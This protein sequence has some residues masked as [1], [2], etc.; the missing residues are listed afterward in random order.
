MLRD[1]VARVL[2]SSAAKL[3]MDKPL[4]NLGLDSLMAVELRNWMESELQVNVPIAEL[5]HS[6]SLSRLSELLYEQLFK[7]AA[8]A[9]ATPS[10]AP[11]PA[12]APSANGHATN[13]QAAPAAPPANGNGH[14]EAREAPA[15]DYSPGLRMLKHAGDQTDGSGELDLAADVVLDEV[16]R[17][18]DSAPAGAAVPQDIFL[19]G[20]T[21][22]LGA[23]LLDEL[24]RRTPA[25]VHCLVRAAGAAEA[26]E[27]VRSNLATYDLWRPEYA[28]RLTA[29]V[30]DLTR[31]RLGLSEQQFND[32]AARVDSIY[33]A[34]ANVQFIGSYAA[35]KPA[36]VHGTHEVL[37]LAARGRYK[38]VHHISTLA[39]FSLADHLEL[40]VA[41]EAD[42][43]RNCQE[44]FVG[45]PQSKWVAEQLVL[46][47]RDRG[48][49]VCVYRSGIVTGHSQTGVGN[50]E[51][52]ISRKIRGCL[53]IGAADDVDLTVDMTPA[54]FVSG[55]IAYLSLRPASVG[56]VYHLVNEEQMTWNEVV[57]WLRQHGYPLRHLPYNRWREEFFRQGALSPDNALF[58]LSPLLGPAPEGFE[59][60]V[61]KLHFD[62]REAQAALADSGLV[63]PPLDARLLEK[64]IAYCVRSGMVPPPSGSNG[65]G[66]G[67]GHGNGAAVKGEAVSAGS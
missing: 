26:L 58:G 1:K 35:L 60:K 28:R 49:P 40:Q 34:G 18:H 41:R 4:L 32:L 11:E 45:Y 55:A 52:F 30:G 36:N 22:F 66:H 61:P 31:P 21:G 29:V 15:G 2:G 20:A 10:P 50:M 24:M 54:D 62:A 12:A 6:P 16:I 38:T 48:V 23:F 9:A 3:D 37:R 53:Q 19:T 64:Y 42:V 13:G 44:L 47:A 59:I 14:V 57:A 7:G 43:P 8:A 17:R 25:T 46:A 67:N 63:C 65:N 56:K 39:V 51:D 33:H 5:M 27:R